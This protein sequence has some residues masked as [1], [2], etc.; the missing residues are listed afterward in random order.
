M[1]VFCMWFLQ[2]V[3]YRYTGLSLA[4]PG[5]VWRCLASWWVRLPVSA[6]VCRCSCRDLSMGGTARNRGGGA[7]GGRDSRA[8]RA[9]TGE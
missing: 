4:S 8:R 9:A 7:D 3:G 5:S 2:Q 6:D 1:Q